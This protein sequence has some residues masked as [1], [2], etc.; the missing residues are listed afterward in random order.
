MENIEQNKAIKVLNQARQPKLVK[1]LVIKITETLLPIIFWVGLIVII[2]V[3]YFSSSF[4]TGGFWV[5]TR[6]DFSYLA[7]LSTLIT[8]LG[9]WILGFYFLYLIIDIRDELSHANKL[10]EV[11]LTP[12]S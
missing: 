1:N 12:K 10:K 9:S 5:G 2:F 6:T 7:F 3:A 11:E 4:T 8:S